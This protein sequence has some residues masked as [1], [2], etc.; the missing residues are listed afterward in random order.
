M[1]SVLSH[2]VPHLHAVVHQS[3]PQMVAPQATFLQ[4]TLPGH[5]VEYCSLTELKGGDRVLP[6][7]SRIVCFPLR[8]KPH[9]ATASW[10]DEFWI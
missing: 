8:P 1:K 6:A 7:D 4:D 5:I 9:E 10:I 3:A 2:R